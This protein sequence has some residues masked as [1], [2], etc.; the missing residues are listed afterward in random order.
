[1]N[2]IPSWQ[3]VA[4]PW[5]LAFE[6]AW[7]TYLEGSNPIAA[8]IVDKNSNVVATGKSAVRANVSKVVINH[9]EIAHAEVN[10][11]LRLDNRVHDKQAA[12]DY[13][14]FSTMEPCPLCMS[15]IYMSDVKTLRYAARDGFGGS[16]NLL[17]TTPY[18]SRKTRHVEGPV[19]G[20]DEVSIFLNVYYNVR[21]A[22]DA[23]AVHEAFAQ[24]YPDAVN[25]ARKLGEGDRLNFDEKPD[26]QFMFER[27]RHALSSG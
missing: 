12:A 7:E 20:L 19:P 26:T 1:M 15:A 23:E 18:L 13:T 5:R 4:E 21:Y 3:S 24:D 11:L 10:A 17:G 9:C 14:L 2:Q 27:V 8:V 6:L 22:T 25:A 16:V